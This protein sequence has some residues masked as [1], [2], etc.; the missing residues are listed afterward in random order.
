MNRERIWYLSSKKLASEATEAELAELEELLRNDPDMHYS[1]QYINDIWAL[2]SRSSAD[3]D[4]AF[5]RH[6]ER[7]KGT[8]ADWKDE[9]QIQDEEYMRLF[10]S[11]PR[12]KWKWISIGSVAVLV[13]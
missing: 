10:P 7:M 1:L 5:I 2:S 4:E 9:K 6:L 11:R 8:G 13:V 12:N 3:A